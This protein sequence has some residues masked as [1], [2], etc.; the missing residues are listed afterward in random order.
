MAVALTRFVDTRP[1]AILIAILLCAM[2]IRLGFWVAV[3]GFG[4]TGGGDEPDYH[5]LAAAI[6]SGRGMILHDELLAPRPP[7]YP[8]VLAGLYAITGPNPDVG[9]AFQ[10]VLGVGIVFLVFAIGRRLFSAK[11]GLLAAALAA[12]N[13]SLVYLSGLLMTE[14][15]YVI[16]LLLLVLLMVRHYRSRQPSVLKFAAGGILAGLCCLARPTALTFVVFIPAAA[17]VF[18]RS[19]WAKRLACAALFVILAVAVIAPWSIRNHARFGERVIFTTHGG[20]TFY[21]S[22]NRLVHD[23]P[24]FR[25]IVVSP[26]TAVPGWDGLKDLDEV[27]YDR[28]AWRMGLAFVRE[29]PELLPRMAWWKFARFWRFDSNVKF[30]AGAGPF[31]GG[32]SSRGSASGEID[33]GLLYW[34]VV[35]P[36]F[37]LGLAVT[38]RRFHDLVLPYGVIAVH[39]FLALV[40]H[41]S[42]RARMP[43]EPVIVL[44]AAAAVAWIALAVRRRLHTAEV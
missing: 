31:G 41:G 14:N 7:L 2:V 40:F 18:G 3:V 44:F 24:E 16:L 19:A 26:R 15:L 37:V 39:T 10:L 4:T 34:M 30:D 12:V 6:A 8:I 21:E 9:R 32:E 1:R 36:L 23:T 5:N 42:L 25:G 13:P 28:E 38:R 33:L 27:S 43:V 17:L 20:I 11:V 22:N 35:I 29:N